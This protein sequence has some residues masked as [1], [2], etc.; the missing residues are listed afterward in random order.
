MLLLVD[1]LAQAEGN[2]EFAAALLAAA[3]PSGP[4][5]SRRRASTPRTSSPPT[6]SPATWPTT[7]TSRSRRS[8]A[9]GAYA[10]AL[11]DARRAR[12]RP[13]STTSSPRTM[14]RQLGRRWPTTATTTRLAFDQPGH[15]E[16]E[17]QPRLGQAPR[18]TT[19]SRPR[20]PER[21]IAFYLTKLNTYGLPLDNREDY[22]KLDWTVWTATLAD[23]RSRLR[24][25][26]S[27]RSTTSPNETPEPRPPDRLVL[28]PR[29]ASS[30]ASRPAPSSAASSSSCW[31]TRR[32]GRS[33]RPARRDRQGPVGRV[34]SQPD[35]PGCS[36]R[37]RAGT[38]ARQVIPP[39]RDRGSPARR[40]DGRSGGRR[41]GRPP[42]PAWPCCR[43]P[44]GT[45]A[46]ATGGRPACAWPARTP[47]LYAALSSLIA[48]S[49]PRPAT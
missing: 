8:L 37:R 14:A 5:T 25:A 42:A 47:P 31:P 16:P 48:R 24:G 11:R 29:T 23:D 21:E 35:L 13:T 12:P 28:T 15:L 30:R 39:G 44:G 36:P 34:G 17:V 9:L 38:P 2:A 7:P 10:D 45:P 18:P 19:S 40:A 26:S 32:P 41:S 22:T 1:A 3:R 43:R 4:T 27:T 33:G 49:P 46:G 6:T 20:S